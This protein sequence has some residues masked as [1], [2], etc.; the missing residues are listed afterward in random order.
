MKLPRRQFLRLSASAAALPLAAR[1]A[2]A[3]TYPTRPITIIV[4]AAVGG[5]TD[6]IARTLSERM[7]GSL[8]QS[9]IIENNGAA[10]GSIAVG[11]AARAAPDGYT[12]SIGHWATHVVNGAVYPLQY[13]LLR[14]LEPVSLISINPFLIAAKSSLPADD[15]KSF[16]AWLKASSS[17]VSQGT[18]G[19]GSPSHVAGALL[20]SMIGAR[21]P[22]VP[23]RGAAPSMQGLLAGQVDFSTTTP[24]MGLPQMRAGR[25]K[26][27]AVMAKSRMAIA[28]DIP[29][30]DEAGLPGFYLSYWHGLWV[31]RGAPKEAIVRLNVAVRDALAD[32]TVRARLTALGQEI[33]PPEQ[34]TPEALGVLQKADIE[35]WWPIIKDAGLKA[36]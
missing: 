15:L 16:I 8:G 34:Q 33:F 32:A 10:G 27:Y 22:F 3:Q 14:D 2:W 26:V 18:S 1:A 12:V 21:W 25:I 13:D 11:R 17:Q 20:Q 24:D 5:P 35:K 28:P 9:I 19:A 23:Y 29:T 30:V 36:E 4:P 7:R 31:P 6:T